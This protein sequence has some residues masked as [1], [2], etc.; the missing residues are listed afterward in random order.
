MTRAAMAHSGA[1]IRSLFPVLRGEGGGEGR[2]AEGNRERGSGEL[3]QLSI[4]FL[5]HAHRTPLPRVR[6][7]GSQI[8]PFGRADLPRLYLY[9]ARCAF[10]L[11]DAQR[12]AK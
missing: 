3:I 8:A 11:T 5:L 9:R 7:R 10:A 6:G 1:R 4:A 12:A 2:A